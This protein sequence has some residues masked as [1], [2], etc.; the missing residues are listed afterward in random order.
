VAETADAEEAC[1]G[2]P[3]RRCDCG[4]RDRAE[5]HDPDGEH[6]QQA[7]CDALTAATLPG[8]R[9]KLDHALP[10]A[11]LVDDDLDRIVEPE[12]AAAAPASE[13]SPEM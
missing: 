11:D 3:V 12:G 6:K 13:R 5:R 9:S 4:R 10:A 8:T 1:Q 2:R 7:A